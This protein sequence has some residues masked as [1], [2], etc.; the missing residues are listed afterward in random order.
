MNRPKKSFKTQKKK[1]SEARAKR[2]KRPKRL[3]HTD[4][5]SRGY[6]RL[7]GLDDSRH[8]KVTWNKTTDPRCG[9]TSWDKP[10]PKT[11]FPKWRCKWCP[12]SRY[13]YH[14]FW[15]GQDRWTPDWGQL[16]WTQDDIIAAELEQWED[17]DPEKWAVFVTKAKAWVEKQRLEEEAIAHRR[18]ERDRKQWEEWVEHRKSYDREFF[19]S[20]VR[21]VQ[22]TVGSKTLLRAS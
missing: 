8:Q 9:T 13:R 3:P 5:R 17:I 21:R 11:E 19:I 7:F 15:H 20:E 18:A 6:T 16:S 4:P 22:L 10:V 2:R 14:F 12:K 1:N